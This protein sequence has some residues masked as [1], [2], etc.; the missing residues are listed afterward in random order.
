MGVFE[1]GVASTSVQNYYASQTKA[2]HA[3]TVRLSLPIYIN[4]QKS[5]IYYNTLAPMMTEISAFKAQ[6]IR[7]TLTVSGTLCKQYYACPPFPAVGE[8]GTFISGLL[9]DLGKNCGTDSNCPLNGIDA[10]EI[11]NEWDDGYGYSPGNTPF[12]PT[13]YFDLMLKEAYVAIKQVRPNILVYT[14]SVVLNH[15]YMLTD[16]A[17]MGA[18]FYSDAFGYHPYA[19]NS[20]DLLGRIQK[21]QAAIK[22][23]KT[24]DMPIILTEWGCDSSW[25]NCSQWSKNFSAA[26]A[27]IKALG[28]LEADYYLLAQVENAYNMSAF[29]LLTNAGSSGARTESTIFNLFQ[30]A[31]SQ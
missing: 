1:A 20:A 5:S 10:M 13:Q 29:S 28:V 30:I 16:L 14:G 26:F 31:A 22:A 12:T 3:E 9:N 2:L 17:K 21:A 18:T 11:G 19:E 27:G 8:F 4:Y 6:G 7:V 25:E 24:T 15:E 23:A